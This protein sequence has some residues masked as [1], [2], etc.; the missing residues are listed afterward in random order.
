MYCKHFVFLA[1]SLRQALTPAQLEAVGN[2][3]T[4]QC[5]KYLGTKTDH[6]EGTVT[7]DHCGGNTHGACGE[8]VHAI[9]P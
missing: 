1:A 4:D 5:H 2:A 7:C 6:V 9:G 8:P 3:H